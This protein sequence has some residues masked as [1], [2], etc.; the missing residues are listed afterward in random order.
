MSSRLLSN[1]YCV[2]PAV[3][4]S[5]A[6]IRFDRY[7]DAPSGENCFNRLPNPSFLLV[8]GLLTLFLYLEPVRSY[9]GFETRCLHISR[10]LKRQVTSQTENYVSNRFPMQPRFSY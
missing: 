3:F 9:S 7:R 10:D 8:H 1:F 6:K 5:L 4:E 2:P